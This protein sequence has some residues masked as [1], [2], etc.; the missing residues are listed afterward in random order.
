MSRLYLFSAANAGKIKRLRNSSASRIA[1]CDVRGGVLGG[2]IDTQAFIVD[3]MEEERKAYRLLVEKYGW[4]MRITNFFSW[5]TG[6]I[7]HRSVIVI[8]PI[9]AT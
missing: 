1:P 9:E 3:S 6:K 4:Q 7:N 8:H 2:W 5:L